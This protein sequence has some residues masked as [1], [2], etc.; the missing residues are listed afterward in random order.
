MVAEFAMLTDTHAHL[1]FP[2]FEKDIEVVVRRAGE[3]GVHRIITIGT[4]LD[5]SQRAI[6][7]AERFP[8]VFA[9]VGIH[10]NNASQAPED[11]IGPL[12]QLARHPKVAALGECGLDYHRLPS[13]RMHEAAVATPALGN[14][15]QADLAAALADGAEKERQ[16]IVFA[17]QLDL[18]AELGL[19]VIVHERD[20][21]DDTLRIISRYTGQFRAVFHCFGRGIEH[22]E[23]IF[24][25][26]HIVSFTGIVTFKNAATLQAC[27][28]AVKRGQFMVETDCP[29]LAPAPHRGKRCEPAHV[30]HTAAALAALRGETP[31]EVAEATEETANHFFRFPGSQ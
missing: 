18:A 19:N 14:E 29:F 12:R 3:A 5:G 22:A 1:D 4:T 15:T 25:L 24:A 27:A 20:A 13:S 6:A 11:V 9:A 8:Q 17:Q 21:W 16:A 23:Q 2:D 7:L 30:H 10:P 31:E 28:A 26:G